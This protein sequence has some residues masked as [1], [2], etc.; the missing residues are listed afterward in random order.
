MTDPFAPPLPPTAPA[1]T[2]AEDLAA[3]RPPPSGM[4][5]MARLSP[6]QLQAI[7][8]ELQVHQVELQ[9]QN[10]QL[11]QTQAALEATQA[12][13]VD[14]YDHAP[15]GYCTLSHKGL[16][17]ETNRTLAERLGLSHKALIGRPFSRFVAPEDKVTD[18]LC[19]QQVFTSRATQSYEIRLCCYDGLTFWAHLTARAT[20][21]GDYTWVVRVTIS[22]IS[23][24][25]RTERALHESERKY[26]MIFEQLQ[27]AV[28]MHEVG[29]DGLPGPCLEFNQV[30]CERL[31]Y[32]PE[33][34]HRLSPREINDP[35]WADRLLPQVMKDLRTQGKTLFETVHVAKD[36]RR[37]P[38]E[39]LTR[40]IE[41]DQQHHLVL[42]LSR[43]ISR[44]RQIEAERERLLHDLQERVKEMR[45]LYRVG[46]AIRR[47]E[48]LPDLLT[49]IARCI[50]A[51]WQYPEVTRAKVVYHG[52]AYLAQPFCET[53]WR[54]AS[55]IVVNG[56]HEGSVE[57]YYLVE[58]PFQYEGPFLR[59]ERELLDNIASS[60][61]QA[62]A[63]HEA[64]SLLRR[65]RIITDAA[66]HGTGIADLQGTILYINES[67]ARIHGYT[68]AEVVGQNLA[69]FH[70]ER[71]MVAVAKENELLLTKG[72]FGPVELGHVHRDGREFAMLMTG[73]AIRDDYGEPSYIAATAIDLSALKR[74]EAQLKEANDR[75]QE[76]IVH[77]NELAD[78]ASRA[79]AAKSEF[80]ANMSHEIRTPINAILG[81]TEL[82]LDSPL[83][84]NQR[85]YA[86]VV[87][88]GGRSLLALIN[89]IL[90]LSKIEAGKLTLEAIEFAPKTLIA[91]TV[92][93]VAVLAQGKGLALHHRLE[94]SVPTHL[95][96][97]PNRLR[98]VL[99]NLV[100]NAVKFTE[101]GQVTLDVS[102]QPA[103]PDAVLLRCVVRDTGI[104]IPLERQGQLFANF[105]Q[106]DAS[107]SRKYGGS[108]LGLAIAK[109]LV[110]AMGGE[111]GVHS[112]VGYG[113]EFWFTVRC[114]CPTADT[115]LAAVPPPPARSLAE[116]RERL[117]ACRAAI[118][119]V[120]DNQT[121][122]AVAK[123]LI[124]KFGLDTTTV[125]SG[126]AALAA[127]RERR[128]D[129]VFM[130]IE[131]PGLDGLATTALIHE[132]SN[133]A[134]DPQVPIVA[135]T[136]HAMAEDRARCL[137]A[138]MND[139]LAKPI[140]P[141][142]LAETLLRWLSV[143]PA[144]EHAAEYKVTV[145]V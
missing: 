50:P 86:E 122:L 143:E 117:A 137:A 59:E 67:F 14:L 37:I 112:K 109:H 66:V 23:D 4:A 136:A 19:R 47:Y 129:L 18:H 57:V 69:L 61:G 108:G 144:A 115:V 34:L 131:M 94:G 76:Q 91:E 139:Y 99:L 40:L 7:V 58:C 15:V 120:D 43:D 36:G 38:V 24:R 135:L 116:L 78:Q 64:E 133:G 30:A 73:I 9:Q 56:R 123:G 72:R 29:P 52:V 51:G 46:E 44:R 3:Q 134:L 11:R 28:F 8:Q 130:D 32:S 132:P 114:K 10:E 96:G 13:F 84:T 101:Q 26:R 118:L 79:N 27:D 25:K 107:I 110:T 124:G 22:D 128:Y 103:G 87:R 1:Q 16:I 140:E 125:N 85:H 63:K 80:L 141:L 41:I 39:N 74:A 65:F 119:V 100:G 55:D 5:E 95:I 33:E 105:S 121:N 138:G 113:S 102:A 142:A 97:D 21:E 81:M 68:P 2:L 6:D 71:Q 62:I 89:D 42:T 49:A 98:Q 75:L 12:R 45:C 111:I 83:D 92:E 17:I 93:T 82:L 20:Q 127:L 53:A 54:Q 106:L 104:G 35:A 31:G 60:L 48:V 90:D 88:S 145:D 77:A 126:Q 70:T